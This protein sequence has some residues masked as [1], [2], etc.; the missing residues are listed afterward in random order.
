MKPSLAA[1]R[2]PRLQLDIP[3][4]RLHAVPE[5]EQGRIAATI[6]GDNISDNGETC[7]L[8]VPTVLLRI[9]SICVFDQTREGVNPEQDALVESI[10]T[11]G[12]Y[13]SV[14]VVR[15]TRSALEDYNHFVGELWGKQRCLKDMPS[16][17]HASGRYDT[18]VAG[19]SRFE[20]I[21]T[22]EV[23]KA[24]AAVAQG[25]QYDPGLAS[26]PAT[27]HKATTP[28]GMLAIQINEN[29]HKAPSQE[30]VAIAMVESYLLGQREGLWKSAREFQT[31]Y[32]CQFS[33]RQLANALAFARLPESVRALV[34]ARS[35]PYG[36]GV[37]LGEHSSSIE[38]FSL[39]RFFD[40]KK[41]AELDESQRAELDEVVE[42]KIMVEATRL[43]HSKLNVTAA[44][45]RY[46]GERNRM[47]SEIEADKPQLTLEDLFLSASIDDIRREVRHNKDTISRALDEMLGDKSASFIHT[48]GLIRNYAMGNRLVLNSFVDSTQRISQE[49]REIA[50]R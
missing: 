20:A 18:L 6:I 11:N 21:K 7:Y 39:H 28:I 3:A 2:V 16:S 27:L 50:L 47:Q 37:A 46:D 23:R 31:E 40:N 9:G 25:K 13:N 24:E 48:Q 30:R 5:P 15:L 1:N 38:N 22:I 19:H 42:S 4:P 49:A 17:T 12:L 26:I 10:S 45:K 8:G 36:V 32:A 29:I 35:I 41:R 34:F 14:D 33:R 43:L 44:R